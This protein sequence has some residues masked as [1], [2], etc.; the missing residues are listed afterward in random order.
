[1]PPPSSNPHLS[2]L[3]HPLLCPPSCFL[4]II[5]AYHL[6]TQA[7]K[8]HFHALLWPSGHGCFISA[9]LLCASK[10]TTLRARILSY[11]KEWGI[12]LRVLLHYYTGNVHKY[13]ARIVV[14][15]SWPM[16][17]PSAIVW[18]WVPCGSVQYEVIQPL[19]VYQKIQ[20]SCV[21]NISFIVNVVL[22]HEFSLLYKMYFLCRWMASM[23]VASEQCQ[24]FVSVS[25]ICE[26]CGGQ[27]QATEVRV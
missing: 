9:F 12:V 25:V 14:V 26:P 5:T 7:M 27:S 24:W 20:D 10:D 16:R 23:S 1:M 3:S 6:H 17:R 2:L 13:P 8:P 11:I 18:K 15:W 19:G 21:F 4:R 22:Y